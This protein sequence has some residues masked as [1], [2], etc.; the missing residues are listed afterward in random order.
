MRRTLG[1]VAAVVVMTSAIELRAQDAASIRFSST[2]P[3]RTSCDT[4]QLRTSRNTRE[5]T[6]RLLLRRAGGGTRLDARYAMDGLDALRRNFTLPERV[7]LPF[8]VKLDD[9]SS[10]LGIVASIDFTAV[11]DGTVRKVR[12]TRTSHVPALDSAVLRALQIAGAQSAFAPFGPGDPG[13]E[14]RLVLEVAFGLED[15]TRAGIDA[16][17]MTLPRYGP[18][19][20]PAVIEPQRLP[21]FAN[22]RA[23]G[24]RLGHVNMSFAISSAG[25][26]VPGTVDFSKVTTPTLA[27]ALLD[28]LP[29]WKF[30]PASIG[31][32]PVPSLVTQ[33]FSFVF[34]P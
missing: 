22:A 8:Y 32:C 21:R 13:H 17:V 16:A 7:A 19:T 12:V 33:S 11:R 6:L 9:S 15:S 34:P 26:V 29:S 31:G 3:A 10:T 25:V 14:L 24:S 27:R 5:D 23:A 2:S 18:M 4:A 30:V 28:V 20:L 1:L